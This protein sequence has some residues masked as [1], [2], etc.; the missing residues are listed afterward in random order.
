MKINKKADADVKK[1]VKFIQALCEK[2][3]SDVKL[4]VEF[5]DGINA[6]ED[7]SASMASITSEY[8]IVIVLPDFIKSNASAFVYNTAMESYYR[9]EGFEDDWI[10]KNAKVFSKPLPF[11]LE[12][13]LCL[14]HYL[15]HKLNDN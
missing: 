10:E 11:S 8:G 14:S 6:A 12:H 5:T 4:E 7:T 1:Y 13:A 9:K 2:L 15:T 3:D